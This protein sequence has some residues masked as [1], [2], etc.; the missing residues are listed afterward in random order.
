MSIKTIIHVGFSKTGTTTLQKNLFNNH[1]QI[2]YLGK[3]YDDK[4][5]EIELHKLIMQ[6]TLVYD[7]SELKK[8]YNEVI[9]PKADESKKIILLSDEML[10]SY[11][12]ARDKGIVAQRLKEVFE[13][14]K[15]VITIRSQYEILK[16][17]Y[18]SRGRLQLNVPPKYSGLHV[19]FNQWLELAEKNVERSYLGHIDY[20]K[21]IDYYARLYGK[22]NV[23]VLLLEEFIQNTEAHIQKL[24]DFLE[25]DT[26]EALT[27]VEG[28]HSNKGISNLQ[29]QK[30]A[31]RTKMF[32]FQNS[33]LISWPIRAYYSLKK[34]R[35][36]EEQVQLKLDPQWQEKI[37]T[38]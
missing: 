29:F 14:S 33:I 20:L 31:L 6:E 18:L 8:H 37:K 1:S 13:P 22:E 35:R 24:T 21:T 32:P 2:H 26:K 11:S 36:K 5:L 4:K 16:A 19:T 7:P 23:C 34:V 9:R 3:R 38:L 10:L 17:A 28:K 12:K 25:I 27:L 15:I 30:E